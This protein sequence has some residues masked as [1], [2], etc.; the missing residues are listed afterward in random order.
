MNDDLILS[1]QH[2]YD[3]ALEFVARLWTAPGGRVTLRYCGRR[4]HE[5]DG[6]KYRPGDTA[7]LKAAAW[8][9][10]HAAR[11]YHRNGTL[12]PYNPRSADVSELLAAVQG[13]QGVADGCGRLGDVTS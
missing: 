10:L 6:A 9:F 11:R 13:I 4:W 5:W 3:S 7:M 1:K 2:P 12:G 8:Q